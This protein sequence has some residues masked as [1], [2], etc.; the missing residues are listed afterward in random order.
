M[1]GWIQE[2]WSSA[3]GLEC[4]QSV[5]EKMNARALDS[6]SP[7]NVQIS[8]GVRRYS[9]VPFLSL[10][11]RFLT[12]Q[13]RESFSLTILLRFRTLIFVWIAM[14]FESSVGS[15]ESVHGY[16]GE[17]RPREFNTCVPL[18][19][20]EHAGVRGDGSFIPFGSL[21]VFSPSFDS[22]M[23]VCSASVASKRRWRDESV[24]LRWGLCLDLG[25]LC[26]GPQIPDSLNCGSTILGAKIAVLLNL[27]VRLPSR[28]LRIAG[29]NPIGF[30]LND[31]IVMVIADQYWLM[32]VVAQRWFEHPH[33]FPPPSGSVKESLVRD[34]LGVISGVLEAARVRLGP[35]SDSR[36]MRESSPGLL[37]VS[38]E[39]IS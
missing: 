30:E 16:E 26:S 35:A 34:R 8:R 33:S 29:I 17:S 1:C 24:L 3:G 36:E 21:P 7:V 37:V 38:S 25:L 10:P 13:G 22:T 27:T 32:G 39:G 18:K 6:W 9:A 19:R 15:V 12:A 5:G 11:C 2:P 31:L 20:A 28:I 4:P 23:A 14:R